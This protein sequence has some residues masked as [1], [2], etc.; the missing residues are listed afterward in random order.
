MSGNDRPLTFIKWQPDSQSDAYEEEE[1]FNDHI[2]SDRLSK[3]RCTFCQQAR[4]KCDRV[5]PICGRCQTRGLKCNYV[6]RK[7]EYGPEGDHSVGAHLRRT[8]DFLQKLITKSLIDGKIETDEAD[9]E[10]YLKQ[11]VSDAAKRLPSSV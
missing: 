8:K 2:S 3:C 5:L 10:V 4:K 6:S 11:I 1:E 7:N 9:S